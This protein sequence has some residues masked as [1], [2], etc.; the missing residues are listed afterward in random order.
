MVG[1][2][3]QAVRIGRKIDA[4]DAGLL[5]HYDVEEARVLMREAV[6][7]LLPDVRGKQVIQRRNGHP[8]VDFAATLEPL[9]V[10]VEHRV[11]DVNEGF[12]AGEKT[13]TPGKQIS[14]EPSL[15]EVLA[16]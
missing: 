12:V 15:A 14:F 11:D 5:V 4:A 6:V 10:L 2:G 1:D 8:P 3:E 16:Q 9:S 13:V 7:I